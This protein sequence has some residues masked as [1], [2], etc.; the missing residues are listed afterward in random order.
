[1]KLHYY[2]SFGA[3]KKQ[4]LRE[5]LLFLYIVVFVFVGFLGFGSRR[6]VR[7]KSI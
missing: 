3:S 1:M 7:G 2:L 4:A 6:K 5:C